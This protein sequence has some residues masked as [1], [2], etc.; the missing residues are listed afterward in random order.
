M[1]VESVFDRA[2]KTTSSSSEMRSD[3]REWLESVDAPPEHRELLTLTICLTEIVSRGE[4]EREM[5][6]DL[7]ETIA[8]FAERR[9][10][11]SSSYFS[12]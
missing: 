12:F 4:A 2:V 6:R 7:L 10:A 9:S 1:L 8:R 5:C 11:S 3:L